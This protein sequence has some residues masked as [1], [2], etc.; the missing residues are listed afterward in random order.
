M[1]I[2]MIDE[3]DIEGNNTIGYINMYTVSECLFK[4]VEKGKMAFRVTVS[5]LRDSK[6][7]LTRNETATTALLKVPYCIRTLKSI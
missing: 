3:R 2:V 4:F 1:K 7:L 5:S 6:H